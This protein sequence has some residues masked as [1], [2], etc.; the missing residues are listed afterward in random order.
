MCQ[1]QSRG[2]IIYLEH[3]QTILGVSEHQIYLIII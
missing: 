3:K 1:K 2:D